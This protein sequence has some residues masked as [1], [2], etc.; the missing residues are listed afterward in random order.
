[1]QLRIRARDLDLPSE[2]RTGIERRLRLAVGR[3]VGSIAVARV[4]LS[5][6]AP[7]AADEA[8]RCRIHIR[9]RDGATRV[10]EDTA[11]DPLAAAGRAAWRLGHRLEGE[12]ELRGSRVA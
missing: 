10:L 9:F 5:P 3:H 8:T 4:T 12:R 1:M 11:S 6:G 2:T 7:D